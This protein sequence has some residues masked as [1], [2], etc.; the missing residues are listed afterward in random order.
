M[1]KLLLLLTLSIFTLSNTFAYE[2]MWLPSVISKE[3][4][5]DMKKKGF[6]LS[7]DDIYSINKASLKDAVVL[8]SGCTGEIISNKG[9]ILTNH[10][11]GYGQIQF[12]SSIE[13]DYLTNGFSAA[14]LAGEL[15][16]NNYWAS[17]LVR[18]DDVT[19][20]MNEGVTSDMNE[21]SKQA[22]LN[23]NKASIIAAATKGNG[24][25]AKVEALYYTNQ[26][27]IFV[28]ERYDD[29]RLVCAP[30]SAIGK[31]GGDTDNWMWP[32]HTG[33]FS[34]FR[35]YANKDNKPAQY[36]KDNVPYTPKRSF[37][38][39]IAGVKENDFTFIYGFPGRTSEYLF[40]DAVKYI[41]YKSNPTKIALRDIRLDIIKAA[42]NENPVTRI[43]YSAKTARIANAWKKWQGEAGGIVKLDAIGKK[44][45]MESKFAIW[46]KGKPEYENLI[47]EFTKLYAAIEPYAYVTDYYNEA[48][49]AIEASGK[50]SQFAGL[51]HEKLNPK[52]LN[53]IKADM[54]LYFKNYDATI[55]EAIANKLLLS[56]IEN[57]DSKYIPEYIPR[58]EDEIKV[59]FSNYFQTSIFTSKERFD[60][61]MAME[62]ESVIN[63]IKNDPFYRFQH[64]FA[65]IYNEKVKN[66]HSKLNS[67]ITALYKN[68]MRGQMEMQPN[69]EFYPDAN[70]TLRIAYGN[71]VGFNPKDGVRYNPVS[72]LDGV[73]VKDNPEI[74]DYKVPAKLHE[75]YKN[76]DFGRWEENGTVPVCIL[77]SNHTTGGNSG[78]P[79]LNGKGEL[80]GLNFDRCWESTMSD[81]IYDND[82]C[83]NI[84][85]DIR[86][87]LFLVEK[88]CGAGYLID[89]MEITEK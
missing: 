54:D 58:N 60:K 78:S 24:Y 27:F 70:S 64:F 74:Y 25:R 59:M 15:P 8:L 4:L 61:V 3:R 43:Q 42:M 86:Y 6:R 83:R 10:H 71:I 28:H 55:D 65:K 7:A 50:A 14:N 62:Y 12:H 52:T 18:M 80:I 20:K 73:I 53:K 88:V 38:I 30:P 84:G 48:I 46:A 5:K 47:P 79:I 29:V 36:S 39:S 89:E 45:A 67:D 82:M 66:Q 87:V 19:A 69:R 68:F 63:M 56:Y 75:V 72:T 57:I 44:Q 1:K 35:I 37:K 32:R 49:K 77:A 17:I 31:F 76:K 34:M 51:T 2:G 81:I 33:D 85:V 9:L 26:Y 40:S 41:A 16:S 21:E 23:A 13:H 11:C 22:K